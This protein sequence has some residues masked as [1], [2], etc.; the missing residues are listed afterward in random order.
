M[1][2]NSKPY[3]LKSVKNRFREH[4][5]LAQ[6]IYN[7][8]QRSEGQKEEMARRSLEQSR[9]ARTLYRVIGHPIVPIGIVIGHLYVIALFLRNP[10]EK[11]DSD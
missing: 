11:N 1:E 9:R 10:F 7:Q 6:L 8:T 4:S 3:V 5:K 2:Q